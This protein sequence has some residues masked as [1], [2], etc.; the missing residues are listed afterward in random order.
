MDEKCPY[1]TH[2]NPAQWQFR[3]R[4]R[5]TKAAWA[6]N[7]SIF[8]WCLVLSNPA[9]TLDDQDDTQESVIFLNQDRYQNGVCLPLFHSECSREPEY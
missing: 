8:T 6:T 4:S 2:Q 1:G 3:V 9:Q 7:F 5:S